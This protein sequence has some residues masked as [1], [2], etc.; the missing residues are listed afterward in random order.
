MS[1]HV[2]F[3][4]ESCHF[5]PTQEKYCGQLGGK[6]LLD[7]VLERY[8]DWSGQSELEIQ[9]VGCLCICDRPCAV[10]L[11]GVNKPTYLFGDL[12]ALDSAS[13]LLTLGELYIESD[14]GMIPRYQL[15]EVLQPARLARIP[16]F[17]QT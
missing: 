11:A 9:R 13:A 7:R 12:P 15:P 6:L 3:V 10:A 1:E 5:S 8:S 16:P 14:R 17:P 2:L 4:C